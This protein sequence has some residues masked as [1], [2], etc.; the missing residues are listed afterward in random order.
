MNSVKDLGSYFQLAFLKVLPVCFLV[1]V[2]WY[3]LLSSLPQVFSITYKTVRHAFLPK[4]LFIEMEIIIDPQDEFQMKKRWIL[5][6]LLLLLFLGDSYSKI[7]SAEFYFIKQVPCESTS[8]VS[9]YA[10]DDSFHIEW[11]Q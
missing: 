11:T 3:L 8:D 10:F 6:L 7:V 4:H 1:T 2:F 5:L 9:N